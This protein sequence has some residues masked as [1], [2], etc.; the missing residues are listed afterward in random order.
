MNGLTSGER[1]LIRLTFA[2]PYLLPS[3]VVAGCELDQLP[4]VAQLAQ[5]RKNIV[6]AEK[7]FRSNDEDSFFDPRWPMQTG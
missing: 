4:W 7:L 1:E 5:C 2:L 6:Y 3:I